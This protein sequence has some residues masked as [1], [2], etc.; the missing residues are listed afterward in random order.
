M[1][2]TR[3]IRHTHGRQA[4]PS[5]LVVILGTTETKEILSHRACVSAPVRHAVGVGTTR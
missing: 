4:L 2:E 3:V 1:S 5:N